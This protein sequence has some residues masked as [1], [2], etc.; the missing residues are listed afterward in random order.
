MKKKN[1]DLLKQTLEDLNQA[2]DAYTQAVISDSPERDD[3]YEIFKNVA[4]LLPIIVEK[5][6]IDEKDN[7]K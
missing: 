6:L 4:G 5:I 2:E 7:I 3:A 1:Y